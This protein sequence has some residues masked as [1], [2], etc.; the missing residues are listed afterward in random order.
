MGSQD[1]D[2]FLRGVGEREKHRGEEVSADPGEPKI[3]GRMAN[4]SAPC[5][6]LAGRNS[7]LLFYSFP[8]P[9]PSRPLSPRFARYLIY[10]FQPG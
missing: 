4:G 2:L 5:C 10:N 3:K 6:A 9:R 1:T 7:Q 8:P